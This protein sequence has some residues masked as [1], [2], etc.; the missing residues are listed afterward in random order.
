[1]WSHLQ[2]ERSDIKAVVLGVDSTLRMAAAATSLQMILPERHPGIAE[3]H[4]KMC[5]SL[6]PV[7]QLVGRSNKQMGTYNQMYLCGHLSN[8]QQDMLLLWFGPNQ[9]Y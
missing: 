9:T 5:I 3:E 7:E 1:M 2:R 8:C 4:Q 6:V